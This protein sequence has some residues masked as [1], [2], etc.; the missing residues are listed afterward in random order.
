MESPTSILISAVVSVALIL[1]L[2]KL[3]ALAL[4][5]LMHLFPGLIVLALIVWIL[6]AMVRTLLG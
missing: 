3:L 2:A 4:A 1:V 6:R 5:E